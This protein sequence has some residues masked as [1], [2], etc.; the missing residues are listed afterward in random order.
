MR[1]PLY[2]PMVARLNPY[3]QTCAKRL[4]AHKP[5]WWQICIHPQTML[6][7]LNAPSEAHRISAM[8]TMARDAINM[9]TMGAQ[10]LREDV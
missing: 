4:E 8:V 6:D 2:E 7:Y 1:H 9:L 10:A 3:E 5:N